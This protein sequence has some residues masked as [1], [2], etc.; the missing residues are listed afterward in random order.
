MPVSKIH[1][2]KPCTYAILVYRIFRQK[3]SRIRYL[4]VFS[5]E[6]MDRL[7]DDDLMMLIGFINRL[8]TGE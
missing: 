7:K 2:S 8:N 6:A 1:T 4:A 5:R 3:S